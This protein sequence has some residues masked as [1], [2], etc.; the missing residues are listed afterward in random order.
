M[1]LAPASGP[2][3][4]QTPLYK[5][6]ENGNEAVVQTLIEAGADVNRASDGGTSP[7]Q[8]ADQFGHIAVA[9]LLRDAG[10]SAGG[11]HAFGGGGAGNNFGGGS[12]P[13]N[14]TFGEAG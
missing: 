7:L 2:F 12:I 8:V 1:N 4:G 14:F 9:Q 5:A 13:L 6:V 10:A 11:N 3:S